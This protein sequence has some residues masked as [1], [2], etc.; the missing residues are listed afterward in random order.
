MHDEEVLSHSIA[1]FIEWHQTG[2]E[3][4][5]QCITDKGAK[6]LIS[7]EFQ[8]NDVLRLRLWPGGVPRKKSELL[9]VDTNWR[10]PE[11]KVKEAEDQITVST[12]KLTVKVMKSPWEISLYDANGDLI[13]SDN[14]GDLKGSLE[15]RTRPIGFVSSA[16]GDYCGTQ[17]GFRLFP[18]E[19]LY[20]FGEKFSEF[21]KRGQQVAIWNVDTGTSTSQRAYKN[22]P[23][24]L[25][26]RG[27]GI[28]VNT[29]YKTEWDLGSTSS[30]AYTFTS[31]DPELDIFFF[32]GPELSRI[33]ELFT[34]LTGKPFMPPKWFFGLTMSRFS[35]KNRQEVETVCS[36]M[37]EY[38][39]PCDVIHL[40]PF[41]LR[42]M[43]H[44][45]YCWDL[46]AFPNPEEMIAKLH[47]QGFK[48]NLWVPAWIPTDTEIFR[49][50]AE[51]GF[52]VKT[53]DGSPHLSQN[54][55][56]IEKEHAKGILIPDWRPGTS[57]GRPDF[58]NPEMVKWFKEKKLRPLIEMGVDSFLTDQS[59]HMTKQEILANGLTGKEMHN[60]YTTLFNKVFAEAFSEYAGNRDCVVV[61]R[62]G[63]VG[64]QQYSVSMIGD[65]LSEFFSLPNALWASLSAAISGI[66]VSGSDIGGILSNHIPTPELYVRWSQFG[67]LSASARCLG[68][69][70]REPWEFGDKALKIFR[71][72]AQFRYRLIPY[73]YSYGVIAHKTG[74]PVMRPMVLEFQNDPSTY[75]LGLQYMLGSELLVAPIFNETSKRDIYLPKGRWIHYWDKKEYLGPIH[76]N[77]EA[78]M[79]SIP[80]F[81]RAGA[82]IPLA[83]EMNYVG[84]KDWDPIIV[85]VYPEGESTFKI[86]D[87]DEEIDFTCQSDKG[88]L[89]I[90]SIQASSRPRSYELQVYGKSRPTAVN[91]GG[92]SSPE[93]ENAELLAAQEQGWW[94]DISE[95]VTHVKIAKI[96]R[97]NVKIS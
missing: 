85:E 21:A 43:K 4:Q 77:W 39:I 18:D 19:E 5:F 67:L 16:T 41:W 44:C 81:V 95:S 3:F 27:Y 48:V 34:D 61:A 24:C 75:R 36:K 63:Y 11:L 1:E 10:L 90:V 88:G 56:D 32:Y 22:V 78:P 35:Y 69:T 47:A 23:F 12:G 31:Q 86:Y 65:Q 92:K 20:G 14:R 40:D 33:L 71:K 96:Q 6:A 59:E 37:R 91:I 29:L 52:L 82:I 64:N 93:A 76:L 57:H 58:S 60:H 72:L 54:Y 68:T 46:E 80:L 30:V 89:L 45:D 94:Y 83:P 79:D 97:I 17:G 53:K 8:S 9:L 87:G 51:K 74:M 13:F 38:N 25:S 73:L 84:E 2:T 28:F 26:T 55:P 66:A 62:S 70:P 15:P 42:S 50:M 49:E 7:L